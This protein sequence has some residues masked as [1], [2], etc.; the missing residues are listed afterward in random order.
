MKKRIRT[1]ANP[2]RTFPGLE[3]PAWNEVFADPALPL[4]IEWGASKGGFLLEHA[5]TRPG[6]NILGTEVRK[7]LVEELLEKIGAAQLRNAHVLWGN[8]AGRIRDFTPNRRIDAAYLFFPD[9]WPKKRHHKRRVLSTSFLDELA[10]LMPPGSRIYIMTDHEGLHGG[11]LETI[12][13]HPAFLFSE[14]WNLE[15]RSEWEDHCL[16]TGRMYW[17]EAF[18]RRSDLRSPRVLL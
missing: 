1:H 13:S 8:I 4:A 10:L 9:P 11:I 14:G 16:R 18:A 2:L 6:M 15:I 17:K 12:A 7:P 5:R 3:P